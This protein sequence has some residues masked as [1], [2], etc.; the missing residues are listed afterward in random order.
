[1]LVLT[2]TAR[3]HYVGGA[4][5]TS[6]LIITGLRFALK[7]IHFSDFCFLQF[8]CDDAGGILRSGSPSR[9]HLELLFTGLTKPPCV[10]WRAGESVLN[11]S[12]GAFGSLIWLHCHRRTRETSGG[13]TLEILPRSAGK[14]RNGPRSGGRRPDARRHAPFFPR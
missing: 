9:N 7:R 6:K 4:I 13:T 11:R 14:G 2:G 5:Q 12:A 3:S 8:R 1:M 10:R